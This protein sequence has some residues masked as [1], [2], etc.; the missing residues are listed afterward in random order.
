[1]ARATVATDPAPFVVDVV[2]GP[3]AGREVELVGTLV[4]RDPTVGLA[5]P[6]DTQ[7]SRLHARLALEDGDVSIEDLGSRNGTFVNGSLLPRGR[8]VLRDGDS[9]VAGS[10]V[11][12][13]HARRPGG[14]GTVVRPG[15]RVAG[16][17]L[18]P[19]RG[20]RLPR[21]CSRARTTGRSGPS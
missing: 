9:F 3:D 8:I 12:E 5:L 17:E 1:M 2:G 18:R 11:L 19:R 6:E 15:S 10:T 16:T 21:R 7:V 20:A 4:G 14:T 13:L